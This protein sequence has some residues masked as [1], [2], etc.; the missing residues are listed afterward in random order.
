[1]VNLQRVATEALMLKD[2][3]Y[4]SKGSKVCWAGHD[5][6]N[7]TSV[8][9]SPDIFNPM[10]SCNKRHASPQ[11]RNGHLARQIRLDNLVCGYGNQSCHG[12]AFAVGEIKLMLTRLLSQCECRFPE[13]LRSRPTNLYADETVFADPNVKL[14]MKMRG[15]NDDWCSSL[16]VFLKHIV[17][18]V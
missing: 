2:G 12:R 16:C 4:I 6:V 9:P 14:M 3:T 1:M 11:Q 17:G 15:G 10:I 13:H 18:S 7:D 5:Y 8:T